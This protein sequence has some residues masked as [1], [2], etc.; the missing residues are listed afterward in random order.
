MT[1][2]ICPEKDAAC[3]EFAAVSRCSDCPTLKKAAMTTEP[4]M[5]EALRLADRIK[6]CRDYGMH[7]IDTGQ[8]VLAEAEL[9]RLHERVAELERV[10]DAAREAMVNNGIQI[11][12][13]SRDYFA[14]ITAID[15]ARSKEQGK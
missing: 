3:E 12:T 5:P 7:F 4:K 8:D 10:L 2:Y 6:Y 11:N 15:A 13:N 9:R 1:T 14:A